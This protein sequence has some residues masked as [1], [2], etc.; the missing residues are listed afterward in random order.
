[1]KNKNVGLGTSNFHR[2]ILKIIGR[3]FY[4]LTS[5]QEVTATSSNVLCD[6]RTFYRGISFQHE[7]FTFQ[8]ADQFLEM[9]ILGYFA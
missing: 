9:V 3:S 1:M 8:V 5:C 7:G 6:A 2:L 4:L